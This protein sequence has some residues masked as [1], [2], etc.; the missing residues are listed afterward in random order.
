M[1]HGGTCNDCTDSNLNGLYL[2]GVVSHKGVYWT[3]FFNGNF[4]E[5]CS[6]EVTFSQLTQQPM[7]SNVGRKR[8]FP[9]PYVGH[10]IIT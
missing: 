1:E 5:V 8:I 10:V 3:T 6:N 2:N 7:V 4:S 9:V